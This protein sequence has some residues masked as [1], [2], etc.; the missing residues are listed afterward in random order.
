M[1]GSDS[2]RLIEELG[3]QI[4]A[5]Y[6][7]FWIVTTEEAR[8]IELIRKIANDVKREAYLFDQNQLWCSINQWLNI[9]DEGEIPTQLTGKN[10]VEAMINVNDVAEK[11]KN[12]IL[13][14]P[15]F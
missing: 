6:P 14:F 5:R 11:G 12:Y 10:L 13:I 2:N 8:I 3:F 9:S 4:K 1:E 15:D 7:Y